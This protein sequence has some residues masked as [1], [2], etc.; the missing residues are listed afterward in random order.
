MKKC[1]I[2]MHNI[3]KR[4]LGPVSLIY[5]KYAPVKRK[6]ISKAKLIIS[7]IDIGSHL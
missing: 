7:A 2:K 3:V 1:A 5:I 6:F 4:V